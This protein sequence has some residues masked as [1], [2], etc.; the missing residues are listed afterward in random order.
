MKDNISIGW[1]ICLFL[2]FPLMGGASVVLNP[3]TRE[4]IS[5]D[6]II[7]RVM[8]FAPAYETIVDEYRANLYIKGKIHI[9]KKNFILR[10][11]PSMFRLQKGVREYLLETYSELHYTAPNIYDQKVKA[12]QGTVKR[13]QRC[14]RTPRIF[15]YKHLFFF[16]VERRTFAF[17]PCKER[18]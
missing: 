7:E 13:N 14:T 18:P 16:F 17:T 12:A 5:V 1:I 6:S 9:R 2:L 4:E 10:Y 15:Q 11:V 8:T 3:Y